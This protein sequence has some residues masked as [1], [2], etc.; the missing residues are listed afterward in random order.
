MINPNGFEAISEILCNLGH[1]AGIKQY[2]TPGEREWL[3]LENVGG[4]IFVILKLIH[5]RCPKCHAMYG[6]ETFEEHICH[7][8]NKVTPIR[9][10]DWVLPHWDCIISK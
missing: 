3:T 6:K 4:I 1:M 2:G 8:L 7:V 5:K 9:E 10:Y